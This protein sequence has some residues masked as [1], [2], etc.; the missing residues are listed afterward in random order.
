MV[1]AARFDAQLL[2]RDARTVDRGALWA[3]PGTAATVLA[4]DVDRHGGRDHGQLSHPGGQP[5]GRS[6]IWPDAGGYAGVPLP[7]R[8]ERTGLRPRG[9]AVARRLR[10]VPAGDLLAPAGGERGRVPPPGGSGRCGGPAA[11]MAGSSGRSTADGGG[12]RDR[13]SGSEPARRASPA[14]PP[15]GS[16]S[17]VGTRIR[18]GAATRGGSRAATSGGGRCRCAAT[19]GGGRCRGA[20]TRAGRCCRAPARGG[21]STR[22]RR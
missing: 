15:E 14:G 7:D 8:G 20:C 17:R 1:E 13:G 10:P 4:A 12:R 3:K 11:A 9:G 6:G 21:E 22:S 16:R 19:S 18:A 2:G 5:Y